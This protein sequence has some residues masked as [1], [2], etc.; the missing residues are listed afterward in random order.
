MPASSLPL[1]LQY[2]SALAMPVTGALI[3][4]IGAWVAWQQMHIA[5]RRL[6]HDLSERKYRI[7]EATR[8]FLMEIV[9]TNEVP[10]GALRAYLTGIIHAPFELDQDLAAYLRLVGE[11]ASMIRLLQAT[12]ETI[13]DQDR[14]DK[15]RKDIRE[16][17]RWFDEQPAVLTDRFMPLLRTQRNIPTLP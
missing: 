2:M 11:R 9:I 16:G 10:E 14:A 6:Q 8:V 5:R 13:D 3:A 1:W 17:L 4:A 12:V 15:M 7:F